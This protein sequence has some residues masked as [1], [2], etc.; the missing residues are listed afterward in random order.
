MPVSSEHP[1]YTRKITRWRKNRDAFDGE[2]AVK[3]AGETYLIAPGGFTTRDYD[4]YIQR[5]EWF[6]ATSR[7]VEGLT[8]AVMA[9]QPEI[10]ADT[11]AL[12]H[13]QNITLTGLSANLL[14]GLVLSD[15]LLIGRYGILLDWNQEEMRPYWSGYPAECIINW[16]THIL[17]GKEMLT[18][19]VIKEIDY[20]ARDAYESEEL[21]RYRVG[22]LDSVGNYQVALYEEMAERGEYAQVNMWT[23]TRKGEPLKFIPLQFFGAR[24]LTPHV[25]NAPMTPLVNVNYTNYRHSADF[26][27]GLFL[28]ALPTPYV[29]GWQA[30]DGEPLKI[31]SLTAWMI[32]DPQAKVGFLEF[33]GQGLQPHENALDKDRIRMATLGARLLEEQPETQ[34]TFGAVRMR[35]SGENSILRKS[36]GLVSEGMS[37]VLRWHHWWASVTEEMASPDIRY[38]L[39][40]DFSTARMT[41]QDL[42]ALMA[43]WQAGG[44]SDESFHW[45][46]QQGEMLPDGRSFEEEREL[47]A[48]RA[49]ARLP[50]GEMST[51][52]E[53]Q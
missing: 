30:D 53:E 4:R 20:E 52:T 3:A 25:Y 42:T 14:A 1:D 18:M 2:D 38:R 24:D 6:G 21:T 23:P 43:V 15:N 47:I 9:K 46:L 26:E 51:T 28:T 29:T 10:E 44:M 49:P 22:W 8:G 36:A 41:A 7:T 5:A 27:H 31:G 34:E 13:M 12:A 39:N 48:A 45:N 16:K 37:N 35:H 11:R 50:F 40:M 33:A 19:Y 32:P 17:N